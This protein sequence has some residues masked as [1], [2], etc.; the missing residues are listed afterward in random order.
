MLLYLIVRS[1]SAS[2]VTK[3]F[4]Y[5]KEWA[6]HWD[7]CNKLTSGEWHSTYIS[8]PAPR[9]VVYMPPCSPLAWLLIRHNAQQ[10]KQRQK[11]KDKDDKEQSEDSAAV[12]SQSWGAHQPGV[13]AS[14]ACTSGP[15]STPWGTLM[16]CPIG[17]TWLTKYA[18]R[19]KTESV[20]C[21]PASSSA[22]ST[23]IKD[24]GSWQPQ[25]ISGHN[26]HLHRY[27]ANQSDALG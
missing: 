8:G 26:M 10:T 9:A 13:P 12:E 16:V 19:H 11:T 15:P 25:H 27:H 6:W 4:G 2:L 5:C 18:G 21:L 17:T 14:Q 23:L 7:G 3:Y 20:L 1:W 22:I 24:C